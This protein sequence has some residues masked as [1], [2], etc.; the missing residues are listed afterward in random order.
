MWSDESA[1]WK[2]ADERIQITIC[3]RTV[4]SIEQRQYYV[5]I[6]TCSSQKGS[7]SENN[8]GNDPGERRV[9][10]VPRC[11]EEHCDGGPG[12]EEAGVLIPHVGTSVSTGPVVMLNAF[13][14]IM[15]SLTLT[16]V[17]LPS[18]PLCKTLKTRTRSFVRWQFAQWDVSEWTR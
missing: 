18:T 4:S 9:S 15:Q 10:P 8:H 2:H 12:S 6:L 5:R 1:D 11:A 7:Y 17:S 14:G 3:L 13:S 16:S